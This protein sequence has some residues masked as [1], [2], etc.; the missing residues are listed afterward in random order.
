M[1]TADFCHG[2]NK[3]HFFQWKIPE[4]LT[5]PDLEFG[6][7][8]FWRAFHRISW[9]LALKLSDFQCWG[10]PIKVTSHVRMWRLA[11]RSERSARRSPML[12][13]GFGSS[14]QCSK[15]NLGFW[16]EPNCLLDFFHS[17]W[18]KFLYPKR[19]MQGDFWP[20]KRD[21]S[22]RK[23]H[24]LCWFLHEIIKL[25]GFDVFWV[26]AK[27]FYIFVL[28]NFMTTW[29]HVIS[30]ISSRPFRQVPASHFAQAMATTIAPSRVNTS[31]AEVLELSSLGPKRPISAVDAGDYS[32]EVA[33]LTEDRWWK[34]LNI[35]TCR[36]MKQ[37]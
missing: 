22:P 11:P 3:L 25:T 30:Y 4:V 12:Q 6:R 13:D 14:F 19:S 33:E 23:R 35:V 31:S 24:F 21:R 34:Q 8:S 10:K 15:V 32:D 18:V 29:Q 37:Y 5:N 20:I 7:L 9:R 26:G 28:D 27:S 1:R 36:M 17:D 16:P 2:S